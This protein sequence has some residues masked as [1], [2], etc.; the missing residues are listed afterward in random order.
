MARDGKKGQVGWVTQ[1]FIRFHGVFPSELSH[2]LKDLLK[3]S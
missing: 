2:G 1:I 3:I